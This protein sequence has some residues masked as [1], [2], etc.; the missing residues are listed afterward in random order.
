LEH[1]GLQPVRAVEHRAGP[2]SGGR[3][4]QDLQ[5]PGAEVLDDQH[6]GGFRTDFS[7]Q[8]GRQYPGIVHDQEIVRAKH[9]GKGG[10]LKMGNFPLL[11]VH[12]HQL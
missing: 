12:H 8:A 11:P 10:K 3:P 6:L 9:F 7:Q 4:A 2:E 1:F 5:P